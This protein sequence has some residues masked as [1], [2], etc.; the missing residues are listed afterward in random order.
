MKDS[1]DSFDFFDTTL[2]LCGH[3]KT[4]EVLCLCRGDN[5]VQSWPG[6]D[7][8]LLSPESREVET[9]WDR[10]TVE[11]LGLQWHHKRITQE[12]AQEIPKHSGSY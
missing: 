6:V 3:K 1:S 11:L 12:D 10:A 7:A 5:I 9:P 8:H 2:L 4:G